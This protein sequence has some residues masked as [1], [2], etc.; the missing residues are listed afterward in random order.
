MA[1]DEE[2]Y[3]GY[4]CVLSAGHS[5]THCAYSLEG[6]G[7]LEW[8]DGTDDLTAPI[9]EWGDAK[10]RLLETAAAVVAKRDGQYGDAYQ[11]HSQTAALWSSYLG[12]RIDPGQ[13]SV[14]FILDKIVRSKTEDKPDHWLDVC[15]YAQVHANVQAKTELI[16][17]IASFRRNT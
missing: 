7:L 10:K 13:V 1:R 11:H 3:S 9:K 14:L 6:A 2:H 15:G 8:G 17:S 5:G 4:V 16:D 12:F